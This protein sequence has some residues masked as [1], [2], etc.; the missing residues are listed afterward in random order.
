[1]PPSLDETL[2]SARSAREGFEL[3]AA[4]AERR[5]Q[6]AEQRA[7]ALE[8]QLR[9]EK[10]KSSPQLE[11]VPPVSG[12]G[13]IVI[14]R[15][16]ARIPRWALVAA[17]PLLGSAYG[18][19]ERAKVALAEWDATV[20]RVSALESRA[21]AAEEAGAALRAEV[22]RQRTVNKALGCQLRHVRAAF[23]RSGV[24]LDAL[25]RGGVDWRSE[26]LPDSRRVRTAPAWRAV[27]DCP[28]LPEV[29]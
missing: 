8:K 2:D 18:V 22:G 7:D 11:S 14:D 27:D 15:R 3:V 23:E 17:I 6:E 21:H 5:A 24:T 4:D 19:Y 13:A 26:Y 16:G 12:G 25:P 1:M 29:P 10:R 9:A 28:E 20:K